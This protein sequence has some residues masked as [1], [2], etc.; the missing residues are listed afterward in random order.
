MSFICVNLLH[1]YLIII[2]IVI[3]VIANIF[4]SPYKPSTV[5]RALQIITR[6]ILKTIP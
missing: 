3:A 4:L 1:Y 2:T 5:A 6:F